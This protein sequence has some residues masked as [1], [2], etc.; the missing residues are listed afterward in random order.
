MGFDC[1]IKICRSLCC[2]NCAVVTEDEAIALIGKVKKEYGLDLELKKYFR[3]AQGEH[4]HYFAVKMI[5]GQCIFLDK[6]KRCRIYRCRP[7]LCELYPVVDID[8]VDARCPDVM[9]NRFSQDM[10]ETLKKRYAIEVDERIRKEQI[11]CFV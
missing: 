2:R 5:K 1:D 6:E 3:K 11:F 4:G 8:V 9:K 7:K 10:L